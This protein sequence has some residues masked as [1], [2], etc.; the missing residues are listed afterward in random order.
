MWPLVLELIAIIA[1]RKRTIAYRN[2]PSRTMSRYD[3]APL[4]VKGIVSY[5]YAW[6]SDLHAFDCF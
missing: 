5:E 2:N 1:Y 3:M 4:F 6:S